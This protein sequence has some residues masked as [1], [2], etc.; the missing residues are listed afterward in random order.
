MKHTLKE[1]DLRYKGVIHRD[2]REQW[3]SIVYSDQK[4]KNEKMHQYLNN[5]MIRFRYVKGV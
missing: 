3:K 4:D 5:L 1:R 2:D